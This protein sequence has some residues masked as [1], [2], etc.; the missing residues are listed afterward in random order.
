MNQPTLF[1]MFGYPGAGKTTVAKL[2]SQLTGAAHLSSDEVRMELF[3][4][5]SYTQAEH[6]M[7]YTTLNTR[8]EELLKEGK[9]VVYDANLNRLIHRIEKYTLCQRVGARS[10]LFWIQAPR[11]LAKERAVMRGHHHLV[12]QDETFESMFE[13]VA[14]AIE[15]PGEDEPVYVIDGAQ[16]NESALREILD[17]L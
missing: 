8:A 5:P 17:R 7:V 1:M 4:N 6:D 10:V 12:P 11:E 14:N 13:R 15:E 16:I 9:S 2:I 3:P